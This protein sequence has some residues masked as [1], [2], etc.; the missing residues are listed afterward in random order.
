[1]KSFRWNAWNL[2]HATQHGVTPEEAESVVRNA[3]PPFPQRT[4][5]DKWAVVARGTGGRFVQVV[6]ALDPDGT[7]YIIHARPLTARRR[8]GGGR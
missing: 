3:R 7:A 6:Y 4:S 2:D 1:M 5:H 8:R